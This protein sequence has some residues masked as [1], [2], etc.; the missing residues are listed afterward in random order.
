MT[1]ERQPKLSICI[2]TRNRGELIGETLASIVSQANVDTEIVVLDG[3]STDDTPNIV[4]K[5][6]LL[7]PRLRYIRQGT[8]GGVDKDF[9]RAVEAASGEYC[10]LMSDDDLLAP[11]AIETVLRAIAQ[12]FS[13]V[14]VNA[15]VRTRDMSRILEAQ[16]LVLDHDRE[17]EPEA[18]DALFVDTAAYMSFIGCVVIRRSIWTSRDR[19]R[20]YGSQFIHA[21]VIF[22]SPLPGKALIIARPLISIRYSN[23]VWRS[24]EF[25]IWMFKWPGLLWSF[26]GIS[27]SARDAVCKLEPWRKLTTLV[28]YRAKGTYSVAEYR[29]WIKPRLTSVGK[30]IGPRTIAMMPGVIANIVSLVYCVFFPNRMAG[31]IRV[32]LMSSPYYVGNW[33]NARAR[34]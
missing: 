33:F 8:N 2:A 20:Y 17:Y 28:F 1:G 30:R 23:A 26:D 31:M 10:W 3:A 25:E 16:R 21:G 11:D 32:D 15:E 24:S 6:R 4:E 13:L 9:D 14:V 29:R 5:Y 22:Q 18:M 19:E 34:S 27:A 12:N 7:C